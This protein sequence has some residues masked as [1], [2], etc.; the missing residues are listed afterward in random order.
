MSAD[1]VK[2]ILF[3]AIKFSQAVIIQTIQFSVSTV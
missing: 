3:Q 1:F 2:N